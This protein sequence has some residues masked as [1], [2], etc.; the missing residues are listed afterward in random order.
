MNFV[1]SQYLLLLWLLPFA[2]LLLWLSRK[3]IHQ[4]LDR[5]LSL[6]KNLLL[7][8]AYD[9]S[10]VVFKG[11][12]YILG[13]LL[14]VLALARPRMGFEWKDLPKG[15]VDIMVVLDLSKSMLASDIS[16]TRLERAKREIVD[17][18]D[19]LEGDRVGIVPFAGVSFVQCPLTLDYRM[20]HMF[21]DQ[22][23]TDYIPVPGT[24]LGDAIRKA[25]EALNKGAEGDSQGKAIILIT[26]GEDHNHD[27]LGAAREAK[28][29]GI[30]IFAIGIG[31]EQGAPIPQTGGG[32]K[33]DS[34]GNVI[35][36]KLDEETLKNMALTTGGTY[37][38]STSGDMDLDYIY[39]KGIRKTID[40]QDYGETR[41][42]VWYERYQWFLILALLCFLL[43]MTLSDFV[44]RKESNQ[45]TDQKRRGH[46]V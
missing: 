39:K 12:I 6:K 4:R 1:H 22:L 21:L 41:Q 20:A 32:F 34:K 17:L 30:K 29:L 14:V 35:I 46:L 38:R 11:A 2:I 8:K 43:E 19:M 24:N 37:V 9:P 18:L 45:K 28:E 10:K 23:S 13:L 33:K 16:P 27:P 25:T 36:T 26:D 3:R 5:F 44:T 42:K 15:G 31:G 7:S 40:D